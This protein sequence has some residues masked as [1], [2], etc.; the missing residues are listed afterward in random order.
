MAVRDDGHETDGVGADSGVLRAERSR[1]P[2]WDDEVGSDAAAR[3][4]LLVQNAPVVIVSLD[5]D[6]RFRSVEG[7]ELR[8]LVGAPEDLIGKSARDLL[9]SL[10]VIGPGGRREPGRAALDRAFAGETVVGTA[11]MGDATVEL[12]LIPMRGEDGELIEVIGIATDVTARVRAERALVTATDRL[13]TLVVQ[14][15]LHDRLASFGTLATGVAHELNNPMTYVLANVE[16]VA[17]RLRARAAER[18]AEER[19]TAA[20][21]ALARAVEGIQRMR[22]IV[23]GLM[24]FAQ[25]SVEHRTLVDVRALAESALQLAWHEIR[26]RA[27]LV[28]RLVEVPPV[29]ANEARL[30]QVFLNVIV[31]AAHAVPEGNADTNEIR[32]T[33]ALDEAGFVVV[34]VADTGAGIAPDVLPRIFDPFFTT[35]GAGEGLGLGLSI[36]HRIVRDL[37]GNIEV[38]SKVGGGSAFRVKLPPAKG[39]RRSRS[40]GGFR[41]VKPEEADE[42]GS[43]LI[44]D[45]DPLVGKAMALTLGDENDVR[46]VTSGR[47]ALEILA[48]GERPDVILCDLMMPAMTGMDLYAEVVQAAPAV[49]RSFVFMTGGASTPRARAFLE[50]VG[51]LCIE[52]PIE[53]KEL[54]EI[55]RARRRPQ[56]SAL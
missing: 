40:S 50:G 3:L 20:L 2:T 53:A 31:N 27:R 6:G 23:Q 51:N 21:D 48:G 5:R 52:K 30:G 43:V 46:V 11:E 42:R 7:D 29:E 8:R 49:V 25:G 37:G 44:I 22:R 15:T 26:H 41:A 13:R 32:V 14:R 56:S 16:W 45:D 34:E 9:G 10:D 1:R 33:S 18:P 36:A 54:R 4:R 47:E 39:W 17:R 38:E 24:T 12:R 19:E 28:D 35:K 55:V